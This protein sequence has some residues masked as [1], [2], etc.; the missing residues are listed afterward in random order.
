MACALSA[1]K[2]MSYSL[3]AW[4]R[5]LNWVVAIVFFLCSFL[6]E[7]RVARAVVDV[8]SIIFMLLDEINMRHD[9]IEAN[10]QR[11][12]DAAY[13]RTGFTEFLR[14]LLHLL[15]FIGVGTLLSAGA[16]NTLEFHFSYLEFHMYLFLSAVVHVSTIMHVSTRSYL[17]ASL[18]PKYKN[19]QRTSMSYTSKMHGV[20]QSTVLL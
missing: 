20:G 17:Q 13:T 18:R 19:F 2:F 3:I 12:S 15:L 10:R 5:W 6:T 11:A 1:D 8:L 9:Q 4:L 7:Y 14:L 16:S